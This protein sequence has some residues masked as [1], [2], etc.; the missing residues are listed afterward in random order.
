MLSSAKRDYLSDGTSL[1]YCTEVDF[2]YLA[3]AYFPWS[4]AHSSKRKPVWSLH[5]FCF[6]SLENRDIQHTNSSPTQSPEFLGA[7]TFPSRANVHLRC[8]LCMCARDK[9]LFAF[10]VPQIL[11]NLTFLVLYLDSNMELLIEHHISWLFSKG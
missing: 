10:G 2:L 6:P 7:Y 4:L 5:S 9:E 3:V 8:V 11:E 1:K